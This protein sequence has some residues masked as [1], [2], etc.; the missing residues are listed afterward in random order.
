MRQAETSDLGPFAALV[1]PGQTFSNQQNTKTLY[2]TKNSY[3]HAQL[4]HTNEKIQK[5]KT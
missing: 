3:V 4:E 5:A 1:E 2:G